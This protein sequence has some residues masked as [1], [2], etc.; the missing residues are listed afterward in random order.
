MEE[1]WTNLFSGY[2]TKQ[3][4]YCR[5]L[6]DFAMQNI[7]Y[8]REQQHQ[9]R[10]NDPFWNMIYLHSKQMA[11]LSDAW[12]REKLDFTRE[13]SGITRAFILNLVGDLQDL[14]RALGRKKDL[15]SFDQVLACTALVKIVG[16]FDDMYIAHDTWFLYRGML[17][18]QKKYILPWHRTSSETTPGM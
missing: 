3:A 4:E 12:E 5:K 6:E 9:L 18:V 16:D 15:H 8:T 11:G 14:E 2:C 1:H 13:I 7:N 17:R 10:H